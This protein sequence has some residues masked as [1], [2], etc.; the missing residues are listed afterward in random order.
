MRLFA[1]SLSA[2]ARRRLVAER[3]R[4]SAAWRLIHALGSLQLAL[5]LLA[6]IA[7]ACAVATFA[8]SG[9]NAKIAQAYI[10]KAP[11]FLL[12]LGVLC[13]NLFAATLTRWPWER[14][15][16]GFIVTHYGIIVLLVGAM[17]GLKT[18]FEGNVTLRKDAPPVTRVVTNRSVIQVEAPG[19]SALYVMPFD[20][21]LARPR[22]QR[23]RVFPVPGTPLKIVATDYAPSLVRRP[24]L[25]RSERGVP[26]VLLEL[27][28]S[29]A[30][31]PLRFALSLASRADAERD[32]FGLATLRLAEE[33]APPAAPVETRMVFAHYQPVSDPGGP[34]V[35]LE[36]R[37]SADGTRIGF[38]RE[39]GSGAI[40]RLEDVLGLALEE[41][42]V[43]AVVESYWPDFVM[44]EGRPTSASSEPRNPAA[45]VRLSSTPA[46]SSSRPELDLRVTEEG[47]VEYALRRGALIT[48]RG[49]ARPGDSFATGWADWSVRIVAAET[50]AEMIEEVLPGPPADP[51]THPVPGF[52]AQ[53]ENSDRT[54]GPARWIESGRVVSLTDGRHVVRIGYGLETRPLPFSLRLVHFEVPRDEGTDAPADFR[55]TVEFRDLRTGETK[56]GLARMNQPASFPGTFWA[57][58]TGLNYK[59]SQAEWNPRDL[60]ETTLQVLYDPGWLLK[61]L[62][63]L[64]I[65]AGIAL[66]FYWRPRPSASTAPP[67]LAKQLAASP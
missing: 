33:I 53:L 13:V 66:Q 49:R 3:C 19:E 62:G 54:R 45:L 67:T 41:G 8:E 64:G 43:A 55:A 1:D 23:P 38:Y 57:K 14:R 6:T 10:Y 61:W 21:E 20:A 12:W 18:G 39:D 36:V 30:P 46:A 59:F 7:L 16:A 15:H 9:F 63:S 26:G 5:V 28:G 60:N 25:V 17:V 32:F 22:P 11:W 31:Q 50:Q 56:A 48:A 35:P 34:R 47:S 40:Y 4:R 52:L 24:Q 44:R 37:L 58:V 51:R 65:C 27:E 29:M 2:A 42:G